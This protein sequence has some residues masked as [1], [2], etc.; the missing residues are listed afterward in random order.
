MT[1]KA[2]RP[3]AP[4]EL[5][6]ALE[7]MASRIQDVQER[8]R[9][10]ISDLS[11]PGLYDL[12]L[13]PALQWLTLH[14]RNCDG[15]QVSLTGQVQEHALSQELRVLV[16]K[17]VRELLRNVVKHSGVRHASLQVS[18]DQE[19][20]CVLVSDEGCGFEWQ[21]DMFGTPTAGFGLWSMIDRVSEVG[22]ELKIDTAPGRG[23]RLTLKFLLRPR[24]DA[25]SLS[26]AT[27]L[28]ARN[29]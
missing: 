21:L 4:P 20:L 22:G 15:L 12:G 23:A 27:A 8:T 29:S 3:Q 24:P 6:L 26:V 17:L 19:E 11:P 5:R 16:F 25:G 9:T 7:E 28:E 1:L 18:G 14:A 13:V 2:I 10:V